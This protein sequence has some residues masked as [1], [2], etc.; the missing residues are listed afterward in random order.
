VDATKRGSE[1]RRLL[2]CVLRDLRAYG[3]RDIARRTHIA[4]HDNMLWWF[5]L[6]FRLGFR[7]AARQLRNATRGRQQLRRAMHRVGADL[8]KQVCADAPSRIRDYREWS[9]VEGFRAGLVGAR[10]CLIDHLDDTQ[11][12]PHGGGYAWPVEPGPAEPADSHAPV[13]VQPQDAADGP[14]RTHDNHDLA[15]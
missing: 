13:V 3:A 4:G 7:A 1:D 5:E 8:T 15:E 2:A 10:A 12:V 14:G 9:R 11:P 6:H